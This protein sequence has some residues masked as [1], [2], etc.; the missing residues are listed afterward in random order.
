MTAAIARFEF[1]KQPK[2]LGMPAQKGVRFED[3]ESLSPILEPAGEKNEP[4]AIRLSKGWLFD[5]AVEDDQLLK[6]QGVLGNEIGF[7]ARQVYYGAENDR[8]AGGLGAMQE[9]LL[10]RREQA[11]DQV[12]NQMKEGEHVVRLQ[13]GCQKLSRDC[14][15]R[16][17]G[18]KSRTDWVISQHRG[19]AF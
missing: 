19:K 15:Q 12:G 16:S 14:N 9:S 8:M 10:E 13:K 6:E 4:E 11:H 17:T 2:A 7:T 18:V 5:L 1:P 3:E